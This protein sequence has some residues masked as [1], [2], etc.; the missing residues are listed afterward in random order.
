MWCLI[1]IALLGLSLPTQANEIKKPEAKI[2][3]SMADLNQHGDSLLAYQ[4][5]ITVTWNGTTYGTK[6]NANAYQPK[7]FTGGISQLE[8]QAKAYICAGRT[9]W[10]FQ[11]KDGVGIF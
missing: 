2:I 11:L 4:S 7:L 6:I 3:F 1:L 10:K 5:K 9:L 8:N